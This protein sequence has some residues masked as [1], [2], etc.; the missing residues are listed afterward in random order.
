MEKLKFNWCA[1]ELSTIY[2]IKHK[3]SV[4]I[5]CSQDSYKYIK[6]IFDTQEQHVEQFNVFYLNR[7]NMIIGWKHIGIGGVAGVV[8][9]TK[10]MLTYC[11]STLRLFFCQCLAVNKNT[12]RFLLPLVFL[13]AA[14]L[15]PKK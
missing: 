4:K 12:A 7:N 6:N 5:A 15:C 11:S 3:P 14:S 8:A 2:K 10:I 9:D 1:A 13:P